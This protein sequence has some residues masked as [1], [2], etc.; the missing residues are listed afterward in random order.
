MNLI[1]SGLPGLSEFEFGSVV[2][3]NVSK[4][5]FFAI[6]DLLVAELLRFVSKTTPLGLFICKV[7]TK[8]I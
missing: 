2:F 1:G 7:H 6:T 3:N 8:G 5:M 4:I